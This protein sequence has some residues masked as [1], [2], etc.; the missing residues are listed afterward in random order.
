MPTAQ[1]FEIAAGVGE[2]ALTV[3][4]PGFGQAARLMRL[5]EFVE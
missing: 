1:L 5:S 2:L 4:Q 3:G